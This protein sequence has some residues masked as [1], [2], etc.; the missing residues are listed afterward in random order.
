MEEFF[1]SS[2]ASRREALAMVPALPCIFTAPGDAS[3]PDQHPAWLIAWIKAEARL[4]RACAVL[5][6]WKVTP[7]VQEMAAEVDLLERLIGGTPARTPQGVIAKL[8]LLQSRPSEETQIAIL[9]QAIS[10]LEAL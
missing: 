1:P 2:F 8:Q 6:G 10:Y 7:E 9:S 5:E 4:S 3:E